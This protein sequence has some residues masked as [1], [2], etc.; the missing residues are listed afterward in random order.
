[1]TAISMAGGKKE[2]IGATNGL[3]PHIQVESG[4]DKEWDPWFCIPAADNHTGLDS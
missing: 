4:G 2:I 3:A 1:M